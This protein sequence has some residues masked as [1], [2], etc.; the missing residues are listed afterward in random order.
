MCRRHD[1]GETYSAA[2]RTISHRSHA[3]FFADPSSRYS[4]VRYRSSHYKALNRCRPTLSGRT[5]SPSLLRWIK[6]SSPPLCGRSKRG[7]RARRRQARRCG[8]SARL[9]HAA[10]RRRVC[11]RTS[12]GVRLILMPSVRRNQA[13]EHHR[14]GYLPC[15]TRSFSG[16][17]LKLPAE[18]FPYQQTW[19]DTV[20][21][22]R[23]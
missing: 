8:P 2:G 9:R 23:Q 5:R 16:E 3:G 13:A 1:G 20:V 11:S 15:E 22:A 4:A 6:L 10:T 17:G 21:D 18:V 19:Q 7:T 12:S 14:S